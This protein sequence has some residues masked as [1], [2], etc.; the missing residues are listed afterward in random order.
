MHACV[1][2]LEHHNIMH[3]YILICPHA[4]ILTHACML[5]TLEHTHTHTH[6]HTSC[7]AEIHTKMHACMFKK[8]LLICKPAC[9]HTHTSTTC[10]HAYLHKHIH[11]YVL[12]YTPASSLRIYESILA[13][14]TPSVRAIIPTP[15]KHACLHNT[16]TPSCLHTHAYMHAYLDS[17]IM[18]YLCICML[19]R[20]QT[21]MRMRLQSVHD[22]IYIISVCLHAY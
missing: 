13:M 6:T 1:K 16:C 4:Y 15:H 2:Q 14:I 8:K 20:L 5:H 21:C 18:T 17:C 3:A 9:F 10:L 22:L 19:T 12:T 7:Y 11:A